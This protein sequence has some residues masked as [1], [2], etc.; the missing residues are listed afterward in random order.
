MR[1]ERETDKHVTQKFIQKVIMANR[2][3]LYNNKI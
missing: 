3:S 2:F 1:K